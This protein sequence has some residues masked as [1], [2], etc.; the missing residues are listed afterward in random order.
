MKRQVGDDFQA[1][2]RSLTMS[3]AHRPSSLD[4]IKRF[5]KQ[6]SRQRGIKHYLALD[7]AAK[8]AGY[9]NFKHAQRSFSNDSPHAQAPAA[10]RKPAPLEQFHKRSL[11][12]WTAAIDAVNPSKASSANWTGLSDIASTIEHFIGPAVNHAHLP[13]GGRLDYESMKTSRERGCLEFGVGY[14]GA[15]ILKPARLT[16]ERIQEAPGESFLLLELGELPTARA[17]ERDTDESDSVSRRLRLCEDLVEANGE[18][19]DRMVWEQG[20]LEHDEYGRE[21]P[22]PDNTRTVSRWLGGKV[23]FVAKG[24]MWNGTPRTY[25]GRHNTMAAND[26]RRVIERSLPNAA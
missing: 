3:N 13:S 22:L 18:Y 25:D 6:L 21:I 23:L 14:G 2:R 9:Q 8:L 1:G 12:K 11:A 17:I 19:F 5:A 15:H 10:S 7:E 24:S 26:T 4:G 16:L 20:Y